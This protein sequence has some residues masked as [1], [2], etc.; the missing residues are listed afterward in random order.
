MFKDVV[1]PCVITSQQLTFLARRFEPLRSLREVPFE[2]PCQ[3]LQN[4]RVFRITQIVQKRL[5]ML[6]SARRAHDFISVSHISKVFLI[7]GVFPER[8]IGHVQLLIDTC[9]DF[10]FADVLNSKLLLKTIEFL[11]LDCEAADLIFEA[12]L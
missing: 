12:F 3:F 5:F 11:S 8:H 6:S 10:G 9:D 4:S 1:D 7:A 2:S